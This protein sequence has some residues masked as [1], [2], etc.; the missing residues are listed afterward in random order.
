MTKSK[1]PLTAGKLFI[2]VI[3]VFVNT[4]ALA[5][6]VDTAW[7]RRYN[8]P[9]NGADGATAIAVDGSGNVYVTGGNSSGTSGDYA[10]IKYYPNGDTAWVRTYNGPGNEADGANAIAIDDSGN[11]YVTGR[12]VGNGTSLDYATIKYYPNGDTAWVRRYNAPENSA[13]CVYAMAVDGSGNVYVT[14]VI[15]SWPNTDY[16]TIKYYSN[17]DTA[18]TRRY[19]YSPTDYDR[20]YAIAVDASGNVYVTGYSDQDSTQVY[21]FDYTTVK[22]YPNGDTA[23]VRRYNGSGNE[24]DV[25]YAIAVDASGNVIVTGFSIESGSSWDYTTI[26][27][28]PNGDTAWL[29]RYSGSGNSWD[30]ARAIAVDDSS[31]VYVTGRS[32]GS[33]TAYDYATI[34]YYPNGDTAW[35][36]RYQGPGDD[37]DE[38]SAIAV[39]DSGNV[40]VTGTSDPSFEGEPSDYVTVMYYPNGDT[41][42]VRGYKHGPGDDNDEP[43]AVAVDASGNVYVTGYSYGSGTDYDYATIKYVQTTCLTI[44]N[45]TICAD[46]MTDL[47]G[48]NFRAERGVWIGDQAGENL[49]LYLGDNAEVTFNVNTGTVISVIYTNTKLT[50]NTE[51]YVIDNVTSLEIDAQQGRVS[52]GGRLHYAAGAIFQGSFSGACT[53]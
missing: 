6:S 11:V 31:N 33:G 20:A 39:D 21:N 36:R 35:V 43:C 34:K 37:G 8:G 44:G 28:Y 30:H 42:W 45:I 25:A 53:L 4:P 48:G 14:S 17:G 23:W 5:Q 49:Y 40:Y 10:T 2:L 50:V 38:A 9:G 1:I 7:V 16:L 29:R 24:W 12:S 22:Y 32:S 47:G 52:L 27:Y 41:A 3:L 18:W 46:V 26:K 51:D 15:G 19:G 13:D